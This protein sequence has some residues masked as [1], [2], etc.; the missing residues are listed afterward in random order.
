LSPVVTREPP[1][2][3]VQAVAELLDIHPNTVR[4]MCAQG[5]IPAVRLPGGSRSQYR[6]RR[7]SLT[8]WLGPWSPQPVAEADA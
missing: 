4:R 2:L 1:L 7:S 6:V 5:M 3:D 8:P